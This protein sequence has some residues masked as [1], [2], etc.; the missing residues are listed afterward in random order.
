MAPAPIPARAL[1]PAHPRS[2]PTYS[3]FPQGALLTE[4]AV[5][6]S[7]SEDCP[8]CRGSFLVLVLQKGLESLVERREPRVLH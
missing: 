7:A 6:T 8:K 5:C 2:G 1:A 4:Q 3:L